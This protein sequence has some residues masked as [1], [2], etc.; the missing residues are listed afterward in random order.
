MS[1]E[2]KKHC[3]CYQRIVGAQR[4]SAKKTNESYST[5]KRKAA[6]KKAWKKRKANA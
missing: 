1:T 5:D 4:E 6:A 3:P 2:C